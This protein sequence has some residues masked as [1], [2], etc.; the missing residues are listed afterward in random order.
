MIW[1]L[2]LQNIY[3]LVILKTKGAKRFLFLFLKKK[4]RWWSGKKNL[5]G[6]P[7][8]PEVV[9]GWEDKVFLK[10]WVLLENLCMT[11]LMEKKYEIRGQNQILLQATS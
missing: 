9:G 6:P 10:V 4:K 7:I 8:L 5:L 2:L 11:V 3:F 1:D